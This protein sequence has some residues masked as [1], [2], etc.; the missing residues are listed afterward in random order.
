MTP[1]WARMASYGRPHW[2][3][4]TVVAALVL[5]AVALDALK[6]WPLKLLVDYVVQ[7]RDLPAQARWLEQLP[8]ASARSGLVAWLAG[9]SL[10]LFALGMAA[11]MVHRYLLAGIGGRMS[12]QLGADVFDRLQRLS[13]QFHRR[14]RRGDLMHRV[15]RD[16]SCVQDLVAGVV[17]PVVTSVV[18]LVVMFWVMV[19]LDGFLA[20]LALVVAVPLW[21][22]MRRFST[23]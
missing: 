16:C 6:P 20:L 11:P 13:P 4:L 23:P 18:S 21:H 10:V 19:E 14:S 1:W 17:L 15:T 12:Y 2:R 5:A 7:G 22:L 3:G 9:G 8:G